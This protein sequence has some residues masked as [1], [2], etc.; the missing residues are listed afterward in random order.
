MKAQIRVGNIVI[1]FII[2]AFVLLGAF[3]LYASFLGDYGATPDEAL[4]SDINKLYS[5]VT[6]TGQDAEDDSEALATNYESGDNIFTRGAKV[7]DSVRTVGPLSYK[8][9]GIA[10][11][12]TGQTQLPQEFWDTTTII[13]SVIIVFAVAGALWK[14][15]FI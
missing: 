3:T 11:N 2:L 14:W 7:L 13:V 15:E 6:G 8:A 10:Q 5:N 12:G 1:S 9:F 4:R